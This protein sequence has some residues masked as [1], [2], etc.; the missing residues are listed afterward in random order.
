MRHDGGRRFRQHR[1][2]FG[3]TGRRGPG[4]ARFGWGRISAGLGG[5]ARSP[6]IGPGLDHVCGR[7]SYPRW[8]PIR[9]MRESWQ[10]MMAFWAGTMSAMLRGLPRAAA[11][12]RPGNPAAD[13]HER[14]DGQ[15]QDR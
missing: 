8:R 9:E 12:E 14:T 11:S 5:P 2:R 6:Q 3:R 10:T 1:T 4:R 7:A 13:R 15:R